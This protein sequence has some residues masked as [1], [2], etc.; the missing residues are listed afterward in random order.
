MSLDNDFRN[1][2][3]SPKAR[4]PVFDVP[5]NWRELQYERALE[6]GDLEAD[7]NPN[8]DFV[9]DWAEPDYYDA[10]EHE[11]ERSFQVL[12]RRSS[13]EPKPFTDA[14]DLRALRRYLEENPLA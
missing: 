1:F 8:M 7:E 5:E 2:R 12:T 3:S 11:K 14:I 9:N 4:K 10:E 13:E 6:N